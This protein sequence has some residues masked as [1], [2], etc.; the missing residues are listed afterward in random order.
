MAP[1][2]IDLEALNFSGLANQTVS[3]EVIQP[4]DVLEVSMVTDFAKLTT[5]TTPIRVADD[6]TVV[7][8]LIGRMALAGLTVKQAEQALAAESIA[9][10]VFRTPCITLT[11]KEWFKN[12]VNV[13][14]AVEKPGTYELP[15]GSSSLMAALVAAEGLTKE[16]GTEVEIRHTDARAIAARGV[17]PQPE[18]N[19]DG[20]ISPA[21]YEQWLS[22]GAPA[23]TKVDLLAAAA[24]KEKIPDLRDGDVVYVAKRTLPPIHVIG[25]VRKPGEFPY[26]LNQ[27]LRVTDALALAGGISNP[28]AEDI[29]VIRR[30]PNRK[31]PVRIAV[32]LQAAK[33]GAD[34]VALAPGDTVTVEHNA[35]TAA[36]DVVQSFVRISVG[37][38]IS[39]F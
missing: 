7:V 29:V 10:G 38:T 25:L 24:G 33:H 19:P 23:V 4:G 15:R 5:S 22:G 28:M 30:L 37:G 27:D 2:S 14:G 16:A 3:V 36:Y 6:G 18:M 26:P 35:L 32:G 13:V 20:T 39:W 9:R 17:A 11:M 8:P 21:S 1:K 34:N 31:E 12:Q